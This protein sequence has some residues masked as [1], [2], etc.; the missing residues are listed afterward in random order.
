MN[1]LV[2][3]GAGFIGSALCLELMARPDTR[4][5]V[6]DKLTYAANPASLAALRA[7][8]GF[9]LIEADIADQDGVTRAF[10]EAAPD[11]VFH[12]AAE[13]HVDR[14]IDAAAPFIQTNVVGTLVML[15]ASRTWW[16]A[17]DGAAKA[18]FRFVHVSTDEVFGSL[19]PEGRFC[20]TTAYDP[21]SP[22][23]ASKAASDHLV[24]AWHRT[25]GLPV[26]ISNC[27]NNYGPRQFPEKLIPLSLLN[28]LH[29]K[30]VSLY[31]DGMNVRDWLHVHDHARALIR[32]AE[33]APAGE[34]YTVGGGEERTNRDIADAICR[35][36]DKRFP[37]AAPHARLVRF[38]KDRP[39]H[40]FRYAIDSGKIRR[41]LGWAPSVDFETGLSETVDWYLANESWWRPLRE[42]VYAG[43]RIGEGAPQ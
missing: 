10:R 16:G 14:S 23:S 11:T 1:Y 2:T 12:L 20:E 3:G 31:G 28:A 39:G 40:D 21:S 29:G 22:Y 43:E 30:P 27:S 9:R 41:E 7:H 4:V 6:L 17:L 36:L 13:T 37:Q 26:V 35:L 19:G 32:M 5:T 42:K 18:R 25:Y 24:R 8:P 34:T 33:A 38:V 15:E